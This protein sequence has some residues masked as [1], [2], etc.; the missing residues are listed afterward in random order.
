MTKLF[1]VMG[2]ANWGKTYT[3][4]GLFDK[5]SFY[6]TRSPIKLPGTDIRF[7]VINMSN[8]D[9]GIDK[10]I[11]NFL[12][13]RNIHIQVDHNFV[14]TLC[15]VLDGGRKD[16]REFFNRLA[17]KYLIHLITLGNDW[18]GTRNIDRHLSNQIAT[19]AN[20]NHQFYCPEIINQR[21]T[22]F[23]QRTEKIKNYI[24]TNVV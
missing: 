13:A 19:I 9:L 8:D 7:T 16:C 1:I 3:L 20:S 17:G 10:Y 5:R 23:N 14:I 24:I 22:F 12:R 2:F 18:S 11:D 4:R 6:H 21:V 15:P